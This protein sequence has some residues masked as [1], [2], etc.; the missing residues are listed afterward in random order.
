LL[1]AKL[2]VILFLF[3]SIAKAL[4]VLLLK[5]MQIPSLGKNILDNTP[6]SR[7]YLIGMREFGPLFI[8]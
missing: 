7:V 6:D 8:F 5:R 3:V 2:L 4:S 1:G